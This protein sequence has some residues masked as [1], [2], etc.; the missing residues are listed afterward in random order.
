MKNDGYHD[1]HY[2]PSYGSSACRGR[3]GRPSDG[4][5]FMSEKINDD[6]AEALV[7]E[8]LAENPPE[9]RGVRDEWNHQVGWHRK[10]NIIMVDNKNN[11]NLRGARD[12]R[13]TTTKPSLLEEDNPAIRTNA[14]LVNQQY[15]RLVVT[16]HQQETTE[17]SSLG[18]GLF[19]IAVMLVFA[20]LVLL[21][22]RIGR[23]LTSK[24][25]RLA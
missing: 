15:G 20:T 21:L 11:N 3:P 10:E 9:E 1:D 7:R 6:D 22:W 4:R 25:K 2:E 24:K 19:Q 17:V 16:A 8:V 5:T 13:S 23:R 18:P 14:G 12:K